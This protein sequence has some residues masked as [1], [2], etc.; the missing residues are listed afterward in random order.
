MFILCISYVVLCSAFNVYY[1]VS[2][3][4]LPE[5]HASLRFRIPFLSQDMRSQQISEALGPMKPW[6]CSSMTMVLR[7]MWSSRQSAH[8]EEDGGD[9][10]QL[11]THNQLWSQYFWYNED[12]CVQVHVPHHTLAVYNICT[13]LPDQ[14]TLCTVNQ[15]RIYGL[16]EFLILLLHFIHVAG[17][18]D[19]NCRP[20]RQSSGASRQSLGE[21]THLQMHRH[22]DH[23]WEDHWRTASSRWCAAGKQQ[24][25]A[26]LDNYDFN[27]ICGHTVFMVK[28]CPLSTNILSHFSWSTYAFTRNCC[29]MIAK[30]NT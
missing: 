13:F 11:D 19:L 16:A 22:W 25:D 26:V 20:W 28:S 24:V 1:V 2:A 29:K 14:C 23:Q 15:W 4:K 27:Y 8:L 9:T 17:W 3:A 30:L 10:L 18:Q 21:C 6:N 12:P 5:I 7:E